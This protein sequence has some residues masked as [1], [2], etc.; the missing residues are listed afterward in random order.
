MIATRF[1]YVRVGSDKKA[2]VEAKILDALNKLNIKTQ[3]EVSIIENKNRANSNYGYVWLSNIQAYYVCLGLNPN[4][5]QRL[6]EYQNCKSPRYSE[7]QERIKKLDVIFDEKKISWADYEEEFEDV[8]LET[9]VLVRNKLPPLIDIKD[10]G[11]HT[12]EFKSDAS[13]SSNKLWIKLKTPCAWL[14][15]EIVKA[16][17]Q[18]YIQETDYPKVTIKADI[19]VAE[20][21]RYG[22]P[23]IGID[24]LRR[25][26]S[27]KSGKESVDATCKLMEY[28]E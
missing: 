9:G 13:V 27:F 20:F 17:F 15:P 7:C 28:K 12:L 6:E 16:E 26:I 10:Y 2:A 3:M 25:F 24:K 22:L 11:L 14:T 4:G 8:H 5:S 1:L 23:A 21:P 19:V 18:K